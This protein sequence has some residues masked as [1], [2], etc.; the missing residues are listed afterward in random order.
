[1]NRLETLLE[2]TYFTD[3]FDIK[4]IDDAPLI[5]NDFTVT[6]V[7]HTMF[8]KVKGTEWHALPFDLNEFS[9]IN[10]KF[11]LYMM[12]RGV[13]IDITHRGDVPVH[14]IIYL[15]IPEVFALEKE[16]L[17]DHISVRLLLQQFNITRKGDD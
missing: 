10:T 16:W 13:V 8:F 3:K 12:C 11:T 15:S 14:E 1:M 9:G 4:N 2:K 5:G 7:E 6:P 17:E